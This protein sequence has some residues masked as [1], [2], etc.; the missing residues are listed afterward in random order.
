MSSNKV[1]VLNATG[2]VGKNACRAFKESGF[3]VFGTTRGQ[4]EELHKIG[5]KP[6]ICNYTNRK[7]LERAFAESG[8]NKVFSITDYFGAA[9]SNG[10]L[11]IEH[12]KNAVDAAKEAGVK[13]FI[14]VSVVDAEHFN[15]HVKHIKTKTIIEDYLK[16]SGVPHSILRPTAFFENLDDPKNWNPL[17][18]GVVK[19]LTKKRMKFCATYDIGRTAAIM[20]NHPE[21]WLGRSLDVIGWEGD[22]SEIAKALEKIGGAPVKASLAMPIFLRRMFLKDLHNMFIYFESG[23]PRGTSDEFKKI[24]PNAL[25]AE[26]WFRFHAFYSNGEMIE[27]APN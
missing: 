10:T 12:G 17:K 2:K 20:F 25:S 15:E 6:I 1:L 11:E 21:L 13:H 19:F 16:K 27:Q 3:E 18:K 24:V 22:L 7:D 9:K 23:G 4:V 8:A 5:V 14:F 26:E